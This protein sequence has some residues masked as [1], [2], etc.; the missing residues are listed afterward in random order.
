[1]RKF[2]TITN[3]WYESLSEI[4]GAIFYLSLIFIPYCL[5]MFFLPPPY[6]LF[7]I[8]W[9]FLVSIWRWAYILIKE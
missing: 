2:L 1:M 8:M 9:P 3:K 7:S 4:K 5:L 6:Y